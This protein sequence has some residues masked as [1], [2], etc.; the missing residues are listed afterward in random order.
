MNILVTKATEL[1]IKTITKP[2]L[3]ILE[4][5]ESDSEHDKSNSSFCQKLI[6][7]HGLLKKSL[8][9]DKNTISKSDRLKIENL[10]FKCFKPLDVTVRELSEFKI[11][12][13][14]CLAEIDNPFETTS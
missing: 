10:F 9:S 11:A 14:K 5:L 2:F 3:I 7:K 6:L 13:S 12:A 8:Y 1:R 4:L